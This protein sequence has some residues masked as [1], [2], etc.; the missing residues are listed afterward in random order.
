MNDFFCRR[1][2]EDLIGTD[3]MKVDEYSF[4]MSCMVQNE[5]DKLNKA[6]KV[7]EYYADETYYNP[8]YI[9]ADGR[10]MH[11]EA[12]L[13]RGKKARETL[14]EIRKRPTDLR[15]EETKESQDEQVEKVE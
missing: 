4:C 6:I 9:D 12:Y 8:T 13:D 15:G 1:C 11:A 3:N 14:D 10:G 2:N 7:L 5:K